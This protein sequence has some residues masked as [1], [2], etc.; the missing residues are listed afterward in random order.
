MKI[1]TAIA[2]AAAARLAGQPLYS[3]REGEP[4]GLHQPFEGVAAGTAAEAVIGPPLVLDLEGGGLFLVEGAAAPHHPALAGELDA[5]PPELDEIRPPQDFFEQALAVGQIEPR[6]QI[7]VKSQVSG[8]VGRL[9]AEEG[10]FVHAGDPLL[11]VK[12][13]PTPTETPISR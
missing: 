12:P 9:Y 7:S 1:L 5:P 4:L 2:P 6:V 11:E 3:L 10:D 13:T 8:V